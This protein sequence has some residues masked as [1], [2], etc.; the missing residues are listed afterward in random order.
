MRRAFSTTA[1]RKS[2]SRD[3]IAIWMEFT[4]L[5]LKYNAINLCHGTPGLS[6]PSYLT[7]NLAEATK[8]YQNNQYTMFLGHPLL[9]EKISEHFSPILAN[10]NSGQSLCPNSQILVT[11]GAIGSIFSAIMN[12]VGPGDSVHMFEPYYSQYVNHVEFSGAK[13]RTSPM[14]TDE[15]GNWHFD[16]E[17]FERSLDQSTKLVLLTNPHN[18]SGKLWTKPEI[19]RMT[20]ILDRHPQVRV[21]SDDVYFFLPFD[22]RKYESFANFST[23]NF[24]KTLTVYS[25]GK[26]LNC[27]GWKVGWMLGP[28]DLVAQAMYVHEA[29]TFN[30]N[31]PGQLAVA[32]S[33]D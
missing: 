7:D 12:L 16:F 1:L 28:K 27:T 4:Q 22:G 24:A 33:M 3:Q 29:S 2:K 19:E 31:V 25:A 8:E 14:Y 13:L 15:A 21:I 10:G 32:Q 5:A 11:N 17:H 9:R 20:E 26:M 23:G 6:P 30:C 18:P